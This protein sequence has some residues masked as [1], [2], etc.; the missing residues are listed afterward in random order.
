[1]S[2]IDMHVHIFPDKIAEKAAVAV[3]K[4]YDLPRSYDGT[5][6]SALKN[7]DRAGI[8]KFCANSVATTP[9]QVQSINDFIMDSYAKYPDRIIPFAAIHPGVEDPYK[10]MDDIVAAGFRGVKIHP[11]IQGFRLDD[12]DVLHMIGAVAGRLPL[13]IHTGDY[14]YDNS[15]PARMNHVLDIFPELTVICAHLGGWGEWE[16]AAASRLPGRK[17]V[18]VDTSST[19]YA[20]PPERATEIIRAY[21][22]ENVFFGTDYPLWDAVEELERFDALELTDYERQLILHRNAERVFDLKG[23]AG[24]RLIPFTAD[25]I[26]TVYD[27]QRRAYRPLYEKYQDAETSPYMESRE[28]VLR[29]YTAEGTT[30]YVIEADGE[31]AGA[32]R[33]IAK[34][35]ARRVTALCVLPERQGQGIAQTALKAIEERHPAAKRWLLDTIAQEPGNCHLYEKLGYVRY[36]APEKVNDRLTLVKY[37][38]EK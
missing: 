11:D 9:R 8:D 35:D 6:S 23:G 2:I 14:R 10:T 5:L 31:R 22:A 12:P 36:G 38:K 37:C 34:D 33:I 28:T 29:K 26:D 32:V 25:M 13:L 7:L 1:M 24:V 16:K 27:I 21:G 17:N 20:V 4:F 18:F 19:L 30:G 3:G 15:G